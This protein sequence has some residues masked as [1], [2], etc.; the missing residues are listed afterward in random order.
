MN[1]RDAERLFVRLPNWVGD[2]VMATGVLRRL[3]EAA[4]N[5]E[6]VL[7]GRG[8]L[9]GLLA[10]LDSFDD[11]LAEPKRGFTAARA[12]AK[13]LRARGFDMAVLLPDSARVAFAPWLAG[14]PV[15]VGY[16][17]DVARKLL[18]SRP[19]PPPRVG[20]ARLAIPMPKRYM[21]ILNAVGI[22]GDAAPAELH[23][24]PAADTALLKRLAA[25]GLA[26]ARLLVVNPGA[27]FGASKLYPP[28]QMAAACAQLA[29]RTDLRVVM[30]PGPGEEGIAQQ[31]AAELPDA[32]VLQDP[33]TSLAE[34]VALT[35][36]AALVIS[37]DTGPRHMAVALGRPVVTLMG[38]TDRR[39]TDY[40]LDD[41]RV[42]LEPVD[43]APCHLKDCPIDHRCM[44][45]LAP[46]RVV[47]AGL[48]LLA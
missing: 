19:L 15:R 3:R 1:A 42:L 23:V 28:A 6:I 2:V 35:A 8:F 37:N 46:E 17:R 44:T 16:A 33:V 21:A 48:E 11:F 32:L 5:A 36:R 4:P 29:A 38:P 14:I 40:Q 39:H 24:D 27:S 34:L 47:D 41:Q 9:R 31:V 13:L 18:V 43:C 45:R 7:E 25:H 22:E 26:D 12:H 10:G 30:A 20:R